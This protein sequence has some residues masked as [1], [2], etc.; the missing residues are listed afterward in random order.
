MNFVITSAGRQALVNASQSGTNA[1]QIAKIGVGTGKYSPTADRTALQAETKRLAIVEGGATGD[2]AIHVAFQD[3]STDSYSIY[4]V[5]IFLAD[6]TLFAVHSS[7]DLVMQKSGAS[8]AFLEIDIAFENVDVS[9]ITFGDVTFSNAQATATN[10]GIVALATAEEVADGTNA[11]KAVTP[12]ALKSLVAS[13]TVRGLVRVATDAESA[14]GAISDAVSTPKGV[15]ASMDARIATNAEVQAGTDAAKTVTPSSL[16]ARTASDARTGLVELAT[17]AETTAGT[18]TARAVTPAGVKSAIDARLATAAE[19]QA[20]TSSTKAVTPAGLAA[21][22]ASET[23]A[24]IV[25]LA[26]SSETQTGTD[27]ARAV[28]PAGLSARTATTGRTGLV[29]LATTGEA[30]AGTDSSRAV[31]PEGV[32]A[33]LDARFQSVRID[34]NSRILNTNGEANTSFWP[35]GLSAFTQSRAGANQMAMSRFSNDEHGNS[36]VFFKSRGATLNTSKSV[37]PSDKIGQINF[38]ADNGNINYSETLQGARVAHI[39]GGVFESSAI[40]SAGTTNTG[41]RGY[42][43]LFAN[44]DENSR[45]GKGVEIL[46]NGFRPTV[47]NN[48]NLGTAGRRWKAVYAIS[49]VIST[50]DESTKQDIADIPDA[51]LEA[52]GNVNF[53][54]FRFIDEVE[55]EGDTAKKYF[56]V[57]AQHILAAFTSAGLDACEYGLVS[58]DTDESG[59]T[60]YGV[61]YREAL[62]LEAAWQRKKIAEAG[63]GGGSGGSTGDVSQ[64]EAD[65]AELKTTVATKANDYAVIH[66]G[67]TETVTGK[68]T[69]SNSPQIPTAA[70]GDSSAN[71]ASTEFVAAGMAKKADASHSHD[72]RYLRLIGGN[73]SG[74]LTVRGVPVSLDG[75]T[76]DEYAPLEHD[77]DGQYIKAS[78]KEQMAYI[79][80]GIATEN[81]IKARVISST[82]NITSNKDIRESGTLLK[83]KYAAKTHTHEISDVNGL[84][85]ALDAAGSSGMPSDLADYVVETG[86]NIDGSWYR[87]YK[88]G[89]VEQGGRKSVTVKAS[90]EGTM[91]TVKNFSFLVPLAEGCNVDVTVLNNFGDFSWMFSDSDNEGAGFSVVFTH[92]KANGGATYMET[93]CTVSWRACGM[94]GSN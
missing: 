83:D 79:N 90:V 15:K 3:N 62:V 26:T 67:G 20:G 9:S 24:G 25:E 13:E 81:D 33:A 21:K 51:V 93:S 6:D 94:I 92:P 69:F 75:H 54:Q 22:T 77:H 61:R 31:T 72:E 4:E 49:D 65:V 32:K 60:I 59:N 27:A 39:E 38:L 80:V 63:T 30:T 53:R 41:I 84:Q 34:G 74:A 71:A 48:S 29:E 52:W 17:S 36:L 14:A 47:D 87:R 58:C 16:S 7:S 28:T 43:R 91:T 2:G 23:A 8:I 88:S 10:A 73:V 50:S 46:D 68:K 37:L 70:A 85:D 89:W 64:L 76:H 35:S 56:G 57:I 18:D 42:L 19:T 82:G 12:N 1:V 86:A 44:S 5:G 40:T 11:Q 45:D 78:F 55:C 66:I